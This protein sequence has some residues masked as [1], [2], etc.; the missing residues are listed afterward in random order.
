MVMTKPVPTHP[1]VSHASAGSSPVETATTPAI[2][3]AIPAWCMRLP[4]GL[5]T[6][7]HRQRKGGARTHMVPGSQLASGG[8]CF[9]KT[10][11]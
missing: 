8:V 3:A 4:P 9:A 2:E 5:A 10:Y 7:L 1:S 11:V 6:D